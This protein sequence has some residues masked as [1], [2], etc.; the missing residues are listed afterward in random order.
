MKQAAADAKAS[1]KSTQS[2]I[3]TYKRLV[4][5]KES[6][7]MIEQELARLPKLAAEGSRSNVATKDLVSLVKN[8]KTGESFLSG[9]DKTKKLDPK[10]YELMRV[11]GGEGVVSI[12]SG[13]VAAKEAQ[14]KIA[15]IIKVMVTDSN[16]KL[17]DASKHLVSVVFADLEKGASA[18]K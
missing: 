15:E 11:S 5:M 4:Q 8:S 1:G 13:E 14:G 6:V 2:M 16:N 18:E 9:L 17:T 7:R 10:T 3:Q 12:K